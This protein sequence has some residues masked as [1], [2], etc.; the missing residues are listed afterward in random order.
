M[1]GTIRPNHDQLSSVSSS[2][3]AD[4]LVNYEG[5]SIKAFTNL[6]SV[7]SSGLADDMALSSY[8]VVIASTGTFETTITDYFIVT[9]GAT[10][11]VPALS[12]QDEFI[13]HDSMSGV[14]TY[15]ETTITDYILLSDAV[16]STDGIQDASYS[17]TIKSQIRGQV[18][19]NST[20][21]SRVKESIESSVTINSVIKPSVMIPITN[22]TAI[23]NPVESTLIIGG[24]TIHSHPS[25][26]PNLNIDKAKCYVAFKCDN[27]I[28]PAS[29]EEIMSFN[30]S[31]QDGYG[32]WVANTVEHVGDFYDEIS[33]FGFNGIIID[34]GFDWSSSSAGVEDGGLLGGSWKMNKDIGFLVAGNPYYF[35]NVPNPSLAKP[36][37]SRAKTHSDAVNLLASLAGVSVTWAIMDQPL[38]NF[39]PQMSQT[40][41]Q[42]ISSLASE[43]G[44][45]LRWLGGTNYMVTYPDVSMG[46]LEVP[47]CCLITRLSKKCTADLNTGIYNPGV[48]T[49]PQLSQYDP[50]TVVKS[51]A[52]VPPASGFG[53]AVMANDLF[54]TEKLMTAL[55]PIKYI[56]LP[57][58]YDTVYI[59]NVT[60]ND[61]QGPFVTVDPHRYFPLQT[62]IVGE[63]INNIDVGGQLK[64]VL[65]LSNELFPTDNTDA[66]N[67]HWY[68]KIQVTTKP[69]GGG[70]PNNDGNDDVE[71]RTILRYRF[72]PTCV[73]TI[74]F[75]FFGAIP[76]PGM[77]I[78][79]T[80]NGQ[81]V[82]GIIESVNFSSPGIVTVQVVQWSRL[83]FYQRLAEATNVV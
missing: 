37:S 45:T 47:D 83:Q 79:A 53:G 69:L 68:M 21:K 7:T 13:F 81:T 82:E 33:M 5:N 1:S 54:F 35:H 66:K 26:L 18:A 49:V 15:A 55:D 14:I 9:D 71:A 63:Y 70:G 38:F 30:L 36:E 41:A 65:K 34:K 22:A 46:F 27:L 8:G 40:V 44:G 52:Y 25:T 17:A 72:V 39:Q 57:Q 29:A 73:G 62:G 28:G 64:P 6:R 56:D 24:S 50:S 74:S 20:M 60:R 2:G 43:V 23:G 4:A 67:D 80:L 11:E 16:T 32:R 10:A 12:G 58:D 3:L 19:R 42:A 31:I 59:Q 78:K 61:P 48:Y 51:S 77:T 76:L 75:A